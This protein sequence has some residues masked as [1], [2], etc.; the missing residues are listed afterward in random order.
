MVSKCKYI[1]LQNRSYQINIKK[2]KRAKRIILKVS[3]IDGNIS[4]TLPKYESEKKGLKFLLKNQEWVLKQLNSFPKKV[5]FK[6]LSEIPYMGKMHKIIHLSKSGNLIYIYKNQIIFF[7]K[8]EN[9]S[10]NI[11]S[12]LYG[13]AK[14]EII[15][16]ANSN[17]SYLGKKY[18]K[19]YIKDLKSSW[20]ICGPSG[21]ISFSWRLILA[22]KH[23]MEYI[24]VHELCHLVEFNHGK[25]FWQLVTAIFPQRDLSQNWLKINGVKLHMIG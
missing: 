4:I 20:G 15:K 11:K 1:K 2:D 24:V 7:G 21:N 14:N 13:K 18:N 16:L 19:I 22:P 3:N 25:E 5:P 23:V 9:L 10:K 8:K 17:V 12:W 6:N